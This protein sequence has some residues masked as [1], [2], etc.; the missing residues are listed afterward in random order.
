ML[1][2]SSVLDALL[3]YFFWQCLSEDLKVRPKKKKSKSL[4]FKIVLPGL[5]K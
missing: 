4:V 5:S 1:L 3:T 2:T